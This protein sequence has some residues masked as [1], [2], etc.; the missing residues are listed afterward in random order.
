MTGMGRKRTLGQR[1][2]IS[3][4]ALTFKAFASLSTTVIVGLRKVRSIS[5]T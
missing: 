4:G 5:L 2:S 3:E 1:H